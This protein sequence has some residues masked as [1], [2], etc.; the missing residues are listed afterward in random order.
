MQHQLSLLLG[1]L[2]SKDFPKYLSISTQR[3]S[4]VVWDKSTLEPLSPIISWQDR[5]TDNYISSLDREKL[6]SIRSKTGLWISSYCSAPKFRYLIREIIPSLTNEWLWG[7]LDCWLIYLLSKGKHYVTDYVSAS[8]TALLNLEDLKWDEELCSFFELPIEKFPSLC[9]NDQ[10]IG[11]IHLFRKHHLIL[12]GVVGDQQGA[13]YATYRLRKEKNKLP[14]SLVYG[15]GAFLLQLLP[16]NQSFEEIY[17]S[18]PKDS[19]FSISLAWVLENKP[20][21]ALE[22]G[23]SNSGKALEWL[24]N[25]LK[26]KPQDL[27]HLLELENINWESL[28]YSIPTLSSKFLLSSPESYSASISNLGYESQEKE[29]IISFLESM[30]YSVKVATELLS[31]NKEKNYIVV[32]G[33]LSKNSFFLELQSSCLDCPLTIYQTEHL[34]GL[35]SIF[36]TFPES[37]KIPSLENRLISPKTEHLLPLNKRFLGWRNR[38]GL[39]QIT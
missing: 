37:T 33:G 16:S 28:P 25:L 3:E 13:L 23:I 7:T 10:K 20:S 31:F 15:T 21:Y 38:L 36:L 35:G 1:Q 34:S 29:L 5:R 32:G 30:S 12:K 8:R 11:P 39:C 27:D 19:P 9:E 14:I 2:D 6:Q 4:V 18:L 22:L 26:I 24:L 17:A